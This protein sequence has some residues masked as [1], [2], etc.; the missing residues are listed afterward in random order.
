[1]QKAVERVMQAY[2]LMVTLSPEEE[3]ETRQ[4][5]GRTPRWNAGR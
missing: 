5:P 1:M 2:T 4:R 3:A